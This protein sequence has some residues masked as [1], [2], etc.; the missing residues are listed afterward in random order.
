MHKVT[1]M[2]RGRAL[3]V[4]MS[5]PENDR[6]STTADQMLNQISMLFGGRIAEDGLLKDDHRRPNDFERATKSP[7]TPV[8]RY[9]MRPPWAPWSM[10]KTKVRC[11]WGRSVTKTTNIKAR[12]TAK[13]DSEIRRILDEQYACRAK[14]LGV[15]PRQG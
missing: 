9:G 7:A 15:Q 4:T 5:L 8:M 13:V 1:I 2:P 10:Q 14:H 11:S 12:D 6:Y 3:G